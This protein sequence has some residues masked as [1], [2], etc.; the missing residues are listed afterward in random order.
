[1]DTLPT[2]LVP[3]GFALLGYLCGSLP[4]AIWITRLFK[5]VDVREAGSGHATTTNTIRHQAGFGPGAL[6]LVLDIAK[7]FLPT[8]LALHVGRDGIPPC[9]WLAPL[10]GRDGSR[11]TRGLRPS[12]GGMAPALHVACAPHRRAGRRRSLLAGF[13]SVS[14][15]DGQCQHR[16]LPA[17]GCTHHL[18]HRPGHPGRP[19]PDPAS[20]RTRQP[21][22]RPAD[23]AGL[24]AARTGQFRH[25]DRR[26]GGTRPG[27]EICR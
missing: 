15:R 24:L 17:G 13:R 9:T 18:R 26:R 22:D 10:V 27:R 12:W 20:Q 19:D 11:L 25:L 7:G 5:G 4:F 23:G 21:A 8:W 2:L 1:M 16:R 14:R 6:V 3:L